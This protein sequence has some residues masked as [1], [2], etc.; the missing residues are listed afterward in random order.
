[1]LRGDEAALY[2]IRRFGRSAISL[3]AYSVSVADNTLSKAKETSVDIL[4]FGL[5]SLKNDLRL[6]YVESCV[7][8]GCDY[9]QDFD[10]TAIIDKP[11]KWPVVFH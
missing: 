7:T 9:V 4:S 11:E 1:V 6:S 2:C 8:S 5:V 3:G 10:V